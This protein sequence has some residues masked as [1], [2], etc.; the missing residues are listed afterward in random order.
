MP[1]EIRVLEAWQIVA[2]KR[3]N[4]KLQVIAEILDANV[5]ITSH[6]DA[7]HHLRLLKFSHP[8]RFVVA[9]AERDCSIK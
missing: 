3:M 8:S 7:I 1:L 2:S 4:C 6:G 5:V 9:D